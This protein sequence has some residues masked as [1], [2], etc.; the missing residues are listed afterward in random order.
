MSVIRYLLGRLILLCNFIFSPKTVKRS[1]EQQQ[2]L[3]S[4]TKGFSMYQLNAC[5]FCVKVR[6]TIKRHS[7]MIELRD[8]KQENHLSDL[9]EQGGKRT[10]PCLRIDNADGDS[11]W[12]YE[13]NDIIKYLDNV[14][15]A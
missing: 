8:I 9:V 12:L 3:N 7:L 4:Q 13:S 15:N 14:A 1:D 10:V 6:R 5:P 2:A 11:T